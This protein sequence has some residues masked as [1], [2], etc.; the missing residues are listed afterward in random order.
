MRPRIE[1]PGVFFAGMTA[2]EK[3]RLTGFAGP[4]PPRLTYPV[5]KDAFRKKFPT[6]N[7]EQADIFRIFRII[8]I[9]KFCRAE[10]IV[11]K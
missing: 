4:P 2:R 3:K 7:N 5:R 11:E 8:F 1:Q 9:E 6:K 10:Y